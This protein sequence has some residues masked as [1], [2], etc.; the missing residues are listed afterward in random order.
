M[1][2]SQE[3]SPARIPENLRNGVWEVSKEVYSLLQLRSIARIDFM[4]VNDVPHVIE[5]NTT[6]GFSA[7]SLVPQM[8]AEAGISITDF[9]TQIFEVELKS[10][11][12]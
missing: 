1:G 11:K 6:P 12:E 8:L 7:A 4:I 9:W 5:V 10:I 3:I 2:Q